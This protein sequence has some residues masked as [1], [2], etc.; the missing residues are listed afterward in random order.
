MKF[1]QNFVRGVIVKAFVWNVLVFRD[2]WMDRVGNVFVTVRV[3]MM[4]ERELIAE[5]VFFF[6]FNDNNYFIKVCPR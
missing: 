6:F 2:I 5:V 1:V 3:F 4:M